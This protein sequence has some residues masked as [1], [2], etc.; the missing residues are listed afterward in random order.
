[1]QVQLT[2][3]EEPKEIKLE[4]EVQ[5]QTNTLDKM[6]KKLF[7]EHNVLKKEMKDLKSELEFLKSNICKGSWNELG[8][9]KGKIA[10]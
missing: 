1:M 9:W 10:G 6:R 5:K 8:E 7:A 4:R 3:F 2:F